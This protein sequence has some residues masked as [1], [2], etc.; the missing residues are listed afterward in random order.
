[1]KTTAKVQGHELTEDQKLDILTVN[2]FPLISQ[3]L[4]ISDE[5]VQMEGIKALLTVCQEE[6][7][8]KEDSVFLV[9][10]VLSIL[11]K[12]A[13]V[14]DNAKVGALMLLETFSKEGLFGKEVAEA[15]MEDGLK[16][17]VN[18]KVFKIRKPLISCLI[19]VSKHI[20]KD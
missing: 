9:H 14:L 10:N 17:C 15:F 5:S 12:K 2:L 6:I 19:A 3:L 11:F 18:D 1:M 13:S 4:M 8:N 7:I 16:Q 20:S